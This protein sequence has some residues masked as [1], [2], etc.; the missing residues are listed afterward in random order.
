MTGTASARMRLCRRPPNKDPL[1][2][3]CTLN[4]IVI[5]VD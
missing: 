3:P 4:F 5:E 1:N 2:L